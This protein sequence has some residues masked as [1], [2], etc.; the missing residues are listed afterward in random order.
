MKSFV[1]SVGT[2]YPFRKNHSV[3]S[4][5]ERAIF[6]LTFTKAGS[7]QNQLTVKSISYR[8]PC[9]NRTPSV[10]LTHKITVFSSSKL[11]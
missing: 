9:E 8:V 11:L 2:G 3:L 7:R 4:A 10:N 5:T 1:A 6:A